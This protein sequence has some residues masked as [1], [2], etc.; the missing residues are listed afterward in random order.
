M[1][2]EDDDDEEDE[3]KDED[4]NVKQKPT[5]DGDCPICLEDFAD[6]KNEALVW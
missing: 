5:D 3:N 4:G 1:G 6:T 2:L